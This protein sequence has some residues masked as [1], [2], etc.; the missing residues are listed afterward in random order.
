M[1]KQIFLKKMNKQITKSDSEFDNGKRI[2]HQR[3]VGPM[4]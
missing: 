4:I 3:H 2:K 1:D